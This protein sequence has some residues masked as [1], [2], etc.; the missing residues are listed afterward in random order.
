VSRAW[1]FAYMMFFVNIN[2]ELFRL[3]EVI[4]SEIV[5]P[6]SKI[7][8]SKNECYLSS[9]YGFFYFLAWFDNDRSRLL[10]VIAVNRGCGHR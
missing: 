10:P 5:G 1:P 9:Q 2:N 8:N 3:A 6:N 4:V 7:I